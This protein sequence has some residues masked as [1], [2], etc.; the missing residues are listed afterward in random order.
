MQTQ[1][2][3]TMPKT[4]LE[5]LV[6][7]GETLLLRNELGLPEITAPSRFRLMTEEESKVFKTLF[8]AET[9][10]Q[11]YTSYVPAEALQ[12]LKELQDSGSFALRREPMVWHA[13]EYDPDPVLVH[14]VRKS[15]TGDW[16]DGM[17]LIARWGDAL[18][19]FEVLAK[20][21]FTK[22]KNERLYKLA[23]M[24]HDIERAIELTKLAPSI[25]KLDT[26]Y[27]NV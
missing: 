5:A 26:P 21:A 18:E 9:K 19:D 13:K 12:A 6:S 2:Y 22:W 24:K 8:P 16:P 1:V 25:D 7:D 3:A 20:K 15:G 23:Q 10:L 17:V 27:L 4:E 14:P 11:D